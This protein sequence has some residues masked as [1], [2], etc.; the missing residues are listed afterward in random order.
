MGTAFELPAGVPQAYALQ[1]PYGDQRIQALATLA[2][3]IASIELQPYEVLVF[4]A[5]VDT[6]SVHAVLEASEPKGIAPQTI[7][8]DA[9]NSLPASAI[10]R[11]ELDANGDGTVDSTSS[12]L[13]MFTFTQPGTYTAKLTVFDAGT[14]FDTITKSIQIPATAPAAAI[15]LI[16]S[17][18]SSTTPSNDTSL[19][20]IINQSGLAEPL[21]VANR[22]TVTHTG[23]LNLSNQYLSNNTNGKTF[24]FYF[25]G[26]AISE[27]LIWNYSQNDAR[28]LDAITAVEIDTGSGFVDRNLSLALQTANAA[29]NKAQVL[30]LGKT[31]NGVLAI[32]ITVSQAETD[33]GETAGGFNEVA[34]AS[35]T[36]SQSPFAAW[37]GAHGLSDD[38]NSNDD[39]DTLDNFTEYALGL[40]PTL[41][42]AD[43]A[44]TLTRDG[45]GDMH[46]R[47]LSAVS[48][49]NFAIELSADLNQW[50]PYNGP[51]ALDGSHYQI[52]IPVN[53]DSP[54]TTRQFL[55]LRLSE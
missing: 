2:G 14:G 39:S 12:G 30:S 23:G 46:Y 11:Y 18:T 9:S 28:G 51:L 10:T 34:F 49:V 22:L 21:T 55:R 32:R 52:D 36:A 40:N 43:D 37:A 48:K 13:L 38:P 41:N 17:V 27:I 33:P 45:A 16:D 50:S 25:S 7:L 47:F 6:S 54:E 15:V 24:T 4:D 26:Q 35:H 42:D 19:A 44:I 20:N 3:R 53:P 31:I 1:S 29:E 8:F 5:T